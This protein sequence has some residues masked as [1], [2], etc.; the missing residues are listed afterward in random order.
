MAAYDYGLPVTAAN[1]SK[2]SAID[3][4]ARTIYGE[5][6][7]EILKGK[8]GVAWVV[9]N[10]VE[11]DGEW[12]N[13]YKDVILNGGF[14]GLT[15]GGLEP[16]LNSTAWADSLSIAKTIK[17]VATSD[18]PISNCLWFNASYYYD[19]VVDST[20]KY[21]FGG[22]YYKVVTKVVIDNQTFFRITGY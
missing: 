12:G 13:T 1:V 10:R 20:G 22:V 15:G 5:A 19:S 21:P 17:T 2:C 9:R 16:D 18:N 3:L 7:G 8:K 14:D 6:E 4:L 11:Y